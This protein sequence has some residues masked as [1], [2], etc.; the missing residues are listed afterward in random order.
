[1]NQVA[2]TRKQMG[3]SQADLARRVG[4]SQSYLCRI[5]QGERITPTPLSLAIADALDS[6]VEQLFRSL[7]SETEVSHE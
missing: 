2:S 4:I 3:I 5:E 1:M 6:S 7:P